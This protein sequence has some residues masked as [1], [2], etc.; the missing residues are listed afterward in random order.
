MAHGLLVNTKEVFP[1][2]GPLCSEA[3]GETL[4]KITDGTLLNNIIG[5]TLRVST[6]VI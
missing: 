4:K 5:L 1:A 2:L 6:I 3:E